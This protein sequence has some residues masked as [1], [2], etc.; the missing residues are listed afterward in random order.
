[1]FTLYD[2]YAISH[3]AFPGSVA[4]CE[5]EQAELGGNYIITGCATKTEIQS[6]HLLA[7]YSVETVFYIAT[8]CWGNNNV[9]DSL[10]SLKSR[11]FKESSTLSKI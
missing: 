2:L 5:S 11:L 10:K 4:G 8:S 1:M 6:G 9:D 3:H 7:S